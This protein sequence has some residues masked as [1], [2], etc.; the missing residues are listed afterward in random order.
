LKKS[1]VNCN[2]HKRKPIVINLLRMNKSKKG[3]K[4]GT[5]NAFP[6]TN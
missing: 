2:I 5:G 1:L 4:N 6:V 3:R